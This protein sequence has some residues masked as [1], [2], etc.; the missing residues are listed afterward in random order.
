MEPT[1]EAIR[2][3]NTSTQDFPEL[4]GAPTLDYKLPDYSD[5]IILNMSAR[6]TEP[7][8]PI[9]TRSYAPEYPTLQ[10]R[11]IWPL[12]NQLQDI[13]Q[14]ANDEF[15]FDEEIDE[16]PILTAAKSVYQSSTMRPRMIPYYKVSE[17][18]LARAGQNAEQ[19]QEQ[20]LFLVITFNPREEDK[21]DKQYQQR[22][23]IT[24]NG[25]ERSFKNTQESNDITI[26]AERALEYENEHFII[27]ND[28]C[29]GKLGDSKMGR[30][31]AVI[32]DP[33]SLLIDME[34]TLSNPSTTPF[35]IEKPGNNVDV[36]GC[37]EHI[38]F[39][40]G[41]VIKLRSDAGEYR[42]HFSQ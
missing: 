2:Y 8:I 22:I 17:T 26:G 38:K 39:K 29:I 14:A 24:A 30:I 10:P 37:A 33:Q 3:V 4:R 36:E 23:R 9:I 32:H 31:Q 34:T 20:F 40:M 5:D 19:E 42:I 1:Q 7:D 12:Q 21:D 25:V 35:Q 15:M 13:P 18:S 11:Q 28:I 27:V 41:D 16:S 6:K